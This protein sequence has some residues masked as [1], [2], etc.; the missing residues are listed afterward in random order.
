MIAWIGAPDSATINGVVAYVASDQYSLTAAIDAEKQ[1]RAEEKPKLNTLLPLYINGNGDG[2]D[3][4]YRSMLTQY[5]GKPIPDPDSPSLAHPKSG[6]IQVAGTSMRTLYYL[7]YGDTL[8]TKALWYRKFGTNLNS[9]V[10]DKKIRYSSSIA[11]ARIPRSLYNY[12]LT[13][14][15]DKANASALQ[16]IMRR[17]LD[18]YFGYKVVVNNGVLTIGK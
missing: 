17:Y 6:M 14:P 12:V 13:V 4:F 7:A 18:V 5:R 1:K 2:H 15:A 10:S 3:F 8:S 9:L 16:A 11:K